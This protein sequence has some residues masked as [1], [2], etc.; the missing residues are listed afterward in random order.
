[1]DEYD[2]GYQ[3]DYPP[4]FPFWYGGKSGPQIITKQ[5]PLSPIVPNL[6]LTA[7]SPILDAAR[8]NSFRDQDSCLHYFISTT[9][10]EQILDEY[11][12]SI[13]QTFLNEPAPI[14]AQLDKDSQMHVDIPAICA[15][16][17]GLEEYLYKLKSV[18]IDKAT[19]TAA[20]TMIGHMVH[21]ANADNCTP[22]LSS[23]VVS[24]TNCS[25]PERGQGRNCI[26][27]HQPRE[28]DDCDAASLFL[29]IRSC[30]L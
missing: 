4:E 6:R 28:T 9:L 17:S 26:Y 25:E 7:R 10:S 19:R 12:T 1:M 11:M 24:A 3:E 13:I 23:A 29:C 5:I 15:S 22:V 16:S 21:Y 27:I 18:I 8:R 2:E 14:H 30:I 20:P